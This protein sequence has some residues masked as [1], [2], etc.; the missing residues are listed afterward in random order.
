M[1]KNTF[2][3]AAIASDEDTV[4]DFPH[5]FAPLPSSRRR[6]G[7]FE[8]SAPSEAPSNCQDL[9]HITAGCG[10]NRSAARIARL[11]TEGVRVI[12]ILDTL[13]L[14]ETANQ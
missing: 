8:P 5:K 2:L 10:T 4:L 7:T 14:V 9:T 6:C 13:M 1:D 12:C 11:F 3:L